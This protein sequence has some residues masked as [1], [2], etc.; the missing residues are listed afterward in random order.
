[1]A[2]QCTLHNF[3]A[4]FTSSRVRIRRKILTFC[5]FVLLVVTSLCIVDKYRSKRFCLDGTTNRGV[6]VTDY[7]GDNF[8]LYTRSNSNKA[9]CPPLPLAVPPDSN[10]FRCRWYHR[11]PTPCNFRLRARLSCTKSSPSILYE[12]VDLDAPPSTYALD[13]Q[14]LA[15]V[16]A[17]RCTEEA[18]IPRVVHYVNFGPR[19]LLFHTLLSVLSVLKFAQLVPNL[20]HIKRTAPDTIF[21]HEINIV[22]HK[23]DVARLEAM[24]KFGGIYC[25]MDHIVLKPLHEVL[26][27][28]VVMGKEE[29]DAHFGNGFFL[30]KPDSIFLKLWYESYRTFD[31]KVW[32]YNSIVVPA[33]LYKE[34][35]VDLGVHVVDSFFRPDWCKATEEFYENLYEWRNSYG[36]HLFHNGNRKFFTGRLDTFKNSLGEITRYILFGRSY[37][38]TGNKTVGEPVRLGMDVSGNVF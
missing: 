15:R 6:K 38:C 11:P 5:I 14:C 20:I 2:K 17:E 7:F 18:L 27:H 12:W 22:H 13:D 19:R 31:D 28:T 33:K 26:Q 4:V 37:L 35:G 21:G 32:A 24:I 30:G 29:S 10:I 1:M 23:S 3:T 25:D 16:I 9:K 34:R 36:V 8:T